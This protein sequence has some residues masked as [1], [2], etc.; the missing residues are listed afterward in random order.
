MVI[1]YCLLITAI[2]AWF[3]TIFYRMVY[4]YVVQDEPDDYFYQSYIVAFLGS[5]VSIGSLY[6]AI[7]SENSSFIMLIVS[8][9]FGSILFL[10]FHSFTDL[11][12]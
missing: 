1:L 4:R 12:H 8:C 9:V 10:F 11:K 6:T 3:G 2:G 5:L 7:S